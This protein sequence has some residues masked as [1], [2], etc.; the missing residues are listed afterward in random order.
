LAVSILDI[1]TLGDA[2]ASLSGSKAAALSA[3]LQDAYGIEAVAPPT[4]LQPTR[5]TE[6]GSIVD[7]PTS[8]DVVLTSAGEKR[9]QVIRV[10]R[11]Q[12]NLGLKEA[13]DL[14]E[15]VPAV[16]R[17]GL[18]KAEAERLRKELQEQGASVELR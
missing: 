13:K 16:V 15:S 1:K 9:T 10:V 17:A 4:F 12:T 6:S 7:E 18:P 5:I 8:F 11:Q 14:V 3:Y 2:V